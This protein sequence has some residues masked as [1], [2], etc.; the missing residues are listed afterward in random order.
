MLSAKAI[1]KNRKIFS[2]TDISMITVFKA[3]GDVNRYRIFRI[4]V[5]QP[6]LSVGDVAQILNIS[7]PLASQHIQILKQCNLLKKERQGK[8]IFTKL[9]YNNPFV[10]AVIRAIKLASQ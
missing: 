9:E 2:E 10:K 7:L 1:S 5:D 3:I 6:K 8:K 4:L